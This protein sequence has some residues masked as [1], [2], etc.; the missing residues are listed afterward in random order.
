MTARLTRF[1]TLLALAAVL[2][3]T[4]LALG[5]SRAVPRLIFP[6]VGPVTYTDDFGAP[7]SQG[8]HEGNDLMAV[9]KSL[10]VAVEPG[11][12]KF[13]TSSHNAGCMLYLEGRSGT[14]YLYVHLNNDLTMK[15]DN[16]GR[17]VAGTAYAKGLRSGQ[18]VVAGQPIGYVGDSG[19]ADG[20]A[21]HLHF[22]IHPGAGAAVDPYRYLKRSRPLLFSARP[23]IRVWLTLRGSLVAADTFAGTV[24]IRV[25]DL[26]ASTGLRVKKLSRLVVLALTQDTMI[27]DDEGTPLEPER[28][29]RLAAKTPV[30]ITTTSAPVTLDAE[31]AKP[32]ALTAFSVTVSR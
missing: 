22:E 8:R 19:D 23:D 7:R 20:I 14:E 26:R 10:A 21:A 30:E 2:V 17:C 16:R 4:P 3:G 25:T 6:V 11:T 31:L 12:V 27:A 18:S 29:E 9:K 1:S 13:W 15:N 32:G 5:G 24:T 28:L